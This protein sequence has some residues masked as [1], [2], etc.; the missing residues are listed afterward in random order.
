MDDRSCEQEVIAQKESNERMFYHYKFSC[1]VNSAETEVTTRCH[2]LGKQSQTT[3]M[4]KHMV[5]AVFICLVAV[6]CTLAQQSNKQLLD[7]S[8]AVPWSNGERAIRLSPHEHFHVIL[9][10]VSADPLR[11]WKESNSWGY[12]A[13]RFEM[14][15]DKGEKIIIRKKQRDWRKNVAD[16]WVLESGESLVYDVFLAGGTWENVPVGRIGN[17]ISM[18]AIFEIPRETMA[19]K[20]DVWTGEVSSRVQEYV[21]RE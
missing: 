13:L 17:K 15:T 8:V 2:F 12:Y 11:I 10:N 18:R 5:C 4:L 14:T 3:L 9:R 6:T 21:L 7:L 16:F 20:L 19:G 1:I